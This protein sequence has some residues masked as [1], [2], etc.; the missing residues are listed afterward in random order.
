[1]QAQRKTVTES[2]PGRKV[3]NEIN[4]DHGNEHRMNH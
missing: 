2:D 1:M 3:G 4:T